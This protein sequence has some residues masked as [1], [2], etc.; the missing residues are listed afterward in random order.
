MN[1]KTISSQFEKLLSSQ[2]LQL[3]RSVRWL[4][5]ALSHATEHH[6]TKEGLVYV[7]F[8]RLLAV[9]Y[10]SKRSNLFKNRISSTLVSLPK[11]SWTTFLDR[12]GSSFLDQ[13]T[14][15][16]QLLQT[17]LQESIS[18]ERAFRP[19]WT[20]AYKSAS[21]T[22]LLPTG[23]DF[24]GLDSTLL[25]NWSPRQEEGSSSLRALSTT[26]QNRSLQKTFSPSFTSSLADRWER[27][28]MPAVSLKTRRIRIYPTP[29]QKKLI[30]EFID[31]S[32]FV[33]N[34][35]LQY[36]N[37]GH[38]VHFESLRDLLVTEETKKGLDE[39][40][41]F[42]PAID[43]LRQQKKEAKGDK[44][45]V[46]RL[47]A[48]IKALQ[49]QRRDKMKGYDYVKNPLIHSFET[50]TP[51]DVRAAAIKRC[52]D[53]FT[54]GFSRLKKGQ[55]KHFRLQYKKKSEKVQTIELTPKNI[56]VKD[57]RIRI[58]P[59]TF[60]EECY[61]HTYRPLKNIKIENNVDLVRNRNRYWLHVLQP[62]EPKEPVAPKTVA[63]VDLGI[64]TFATVYSYS[65]DETR[66]TEYK[67]RAE[68]L[69]E[70]NRKINTLKHLRRTLYK[71]I[72]KGK[73]RKKR[74]RKKQI[75]KLEKR[76][77]DLVDRL[78]WDF[79]NHILE[80]NDVVYL[81]DIKSH[82]IVKDGKSRFLNLAFND[83]KL[84]QLKQRL[85]YKAFVYGKKVIMVP[86][87]Y[88]TKTCSCCG[89]INDKVGSK[90]T[91][92][93]SSCKIVTGRDMNAS[94]NMMLKGFFS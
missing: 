68:A 37:N 16:I 79:V 90:D 60:K 43:S 89:N 29:K 92:A 2:G 11:S 27:G 67:H 23:I 65:K 13:S 34:R 61:L 56:S 38:K 18:R 81:G 59:E 17:L 58:V 33:Y 39:Y 73:K 53:A 93:C 25:T 80:H 47:E 77:G 66:I 10:L 35:A 84:Y 42:D 52:C 62:T 64:R 83:L 7:V 14:L 28:A 48:Q 86:E 91:F 51:K 1:A 41:A 21:E 88:T 6:P 69:K 54:S 50:N 22:L 24:V 70:L 26:L 82:D 45:A 8:K 20:P 76:K 46:E 87:Q 55:I 12:L 9:L 4:T 3:L 5:R 94:K 57:N 75:S 30:D 15:H 44:E 31:T 40:K 74:I 19:F 85:M 71:P 72:K 63:G 36:I 78:H 49:Q 32:R